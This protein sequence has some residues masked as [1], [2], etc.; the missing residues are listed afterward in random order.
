MC[1]KSYEA[2]EAIRPR[3]N[4]IHLRIPCQVG[5]F[6]YAELPKCGNGIYGQFRIKYDGS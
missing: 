6:A 1:N 4:R 5:A 2:K 3:H